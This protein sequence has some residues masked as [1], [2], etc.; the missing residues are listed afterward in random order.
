MNGFQLPTDLK[1]YEVTSFGN[2][3]AYEITDIHSGESVWFQ[4]DDAD[5]VRANSGDFSS[6]DYIDN[7]FY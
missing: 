3:W 7:Y 5:I 6:D 2:G 1:R 4:D